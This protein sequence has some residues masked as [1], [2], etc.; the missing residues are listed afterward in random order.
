VKDTVFDGQV[1]SEKR[2]NLLYDEG[3]RHY[4][5]I[6]NITGAM[7]KRYVCKECGKD[8]LKGTM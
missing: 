1:Q 5:V 3:T 7:A 6:T 8:V 4:H 2:L